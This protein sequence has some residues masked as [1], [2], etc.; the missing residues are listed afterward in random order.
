MYFV[1]YKNYRVLNAY[2]NN[3]LEK[4]N[5]IEE[6]YLNCY[7]SINGAAIVFKDAQKTNVYLVVLSWLAS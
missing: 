3:D 7:T 6:I 5:S 1:S 2:I 4:K